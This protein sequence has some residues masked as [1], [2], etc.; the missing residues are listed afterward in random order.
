MND[1]A[2]LLIVA[3]VLIVAFV[4]FGNKL[5]KGGKHEGYKHH[6]LA[7]VGIASFTR[8]PL[9]YAFVG[10]DYQRANPHYETDPY[11][12]YHSLEA[13]PVDFYPDSRKLQDGRIFEDMMPEWGG[14]GGADVPNDSYT[15]PT[16]QNLGFVG[17]AR[18]MAAA[19]PHGMDAAP[20]P[21]THDMLKIA[22]SDVQV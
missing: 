14:Y 1:K 4:L 13:G 16:L 17:A 5:F 6:N 12:Y 9:D 2:I 8:S 15:R 22:R 18:A 19:L 7:Q 11:N 20:H 21:V 3:I 10:P